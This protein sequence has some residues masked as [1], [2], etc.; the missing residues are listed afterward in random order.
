MLLKCIFLLFLSTD[1]SNT[2][3]SIKLEYYTKPIPT[4]E[5]SI[6]YKRVGKE[7]SIKV[8]NYHGESF[9]RPFNLEKYVS[10]VKK[11]N[12]AGIWSIRDCCPPNSPNG[13]Y[14][15]EVS[16]PK[17]ENSF[18]AEANVP[19][20]GRCAGINEIMRHIENNAKLVIYDMQKEK[21]NDR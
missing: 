1:S 6:E 13:Y 7:V 4:K 17:G 12:A 14:L 11:L 3:Y 18:K 2:D 5:W 9:E 15:I 16:S 21:E 10:L 8:D 19:P 20:T